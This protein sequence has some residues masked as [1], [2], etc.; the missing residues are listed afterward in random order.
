MFEI[1]EEATALA[2]KI[3]TARRIH[4]VSTLLT[5]SVIAS[6]ILH[7]VVFHDLYGVL[8]VLLLAFGSM[9]STIESIIEEYEDEDIELQQEF[10]DRLEQINRDR[11]VIQYD[12]V[13]EDGQEDL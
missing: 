4:N 7:S 2:K 8:I 5:W 1:K 9:G 12:T 6:L 3:K 11:I 13:D 10:T